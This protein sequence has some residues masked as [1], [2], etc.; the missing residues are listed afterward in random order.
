MRPFHLD[1]L[2]P[3]E[4]SNLFNQ[5]NLPEAEREEQFHVFGRNSF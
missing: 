5:W 4:N 1:L 2:K 3:Y